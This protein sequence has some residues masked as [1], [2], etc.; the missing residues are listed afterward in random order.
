MQTITVQDNV[1]DA[2]REIPVEDQGKRVLT[3]NG[4]TVAQEEEILRREK[5]TENFTDP[6]DM[7]EYIQLLEA[8]I[9]SNE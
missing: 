8:R 5:D 3:A 4:L 6:I 9:K 1:A 7:D 2:L